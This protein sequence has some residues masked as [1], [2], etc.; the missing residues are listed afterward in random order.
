MRLPLSKVHRAFPELDRFSDEQCGRFVRAAGRRGWRPWV[1]RAVLGA[2]TF[3]LTVGSVYGAIAASSWAEKWLR[4][5]EIAFWVTVSLSLAVACLIPTVLVMLLRDRMLLGRVRH[6]VRARAVCP[7]CR[8]SLL[9][10]VVRGDGIV[11]CPECGME[12]EADPSMKELVTDEQG[13]T[14]FQPT[15]RVD[16]RVFWTERR[17][18]WAKRAAVVLAA[19][20]LVVAPAGLGG[21]ELFL[22]RQAAAA[23]AERPGA[24]GVM[25]FVES[26]QPAGVSAADRNAWDVLYESAMA[27]QLIDDRVSRQPPYA[28]AN[29]GRGLFPE[30]ETIFAPRDN[31]DDPDRA[32]EDALLRGLCEELLGA[33]REAGLLDGLDSI[34]GAPRAVEPVHAPTGQPLLMAALPTLADARL[35]ARM[36]AARMHLAAD[37]GD[38]EEFLR[39]F[40]CT[41]GLARL[42]K[43]QAP[44]IQTLSA[45]AIEGLALGQARRCILR[46]PGAEWLDGIEAA[47]ARQDP[48]LA[49]AHA[50]EGERL[51]MLDAIGYVFADPGRVRLGRFSEFVRGLSGGR[52]DAL[53]ARLGTYAENRDAANAHFDSAVGAG[54]LD[55]FER[56]AI[57]ASPTD[58]ILLNFF[59]PALHRSLRTADE[60]EGERRALA[61]MLALERRRLAEGV[62]PDSLAELVPGWLGALPPDPWT[63][64]PLGYSRLGEGYDL[65]AAGPETPGQAPA[66]PASERRGLR[67]SPIDD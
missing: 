33:Y 27:R 12:V 66:G 1:H 22:R 61:V 23:G 59:M 14:R 5:G 55:P 42:G 31:A 19:F 6:I 20:L 53:R 44:L 30:W 36:N 43:H 25:A 9:G 58:L 63:G 15:E 8:Y 38:R 50:I 10:I 57:E 65:W 49:R 26:H 51:Y 52:L 16:G 3:P 32:L 40:E 21:Y 17:L 35:F 46:H 45:C 60:N 62:Y 2:I 18:R 67:Y 28:D 41:L 56:P 11:V 48:G 4:L 47:L 37:A 7:G 24:A 64:V 34:A 39:A 29:G 13:R 54:A